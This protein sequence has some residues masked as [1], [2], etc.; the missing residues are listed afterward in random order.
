MAHTCF[1]EK[2]RGR[3]ANPGCRI[4]QDMIDGCTYDKLRTTTIGNFALEYG[5]WCCVYT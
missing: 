5:T 2:K 1:K 4:L 3:Y